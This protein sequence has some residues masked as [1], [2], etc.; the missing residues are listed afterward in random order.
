M[1]KNTST[2]SFD[3]FIRDL[4]IGFGMSSD[5]VEIMWKTQG[6]S[7]QA[8]ASKSF[9]NK[10]LVHVGNKIHQSQLHPGPHLEDL[11][12]Q[13]LTQIEKRLLW[14]SIKHMDIALPT[15]GTSV[16][17]LPLYKWCADVLVNAAT[18]AFFGESLLRD[19][20]ELLQ[21]FYA[22]DDDSWMLTYQYPRFLARN[23]H[24]AKTNITNAFTRYYQLPLEERSRA[25]YHVRMQEARQR[26]AALGE[27][28][29]AI[30]TQMFYWV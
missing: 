24:S 16:V 29:M 3:S 19:N 18:R 14:E 21:D 26:E 28:D 22:F 30:I 8:E 23:L 20:P 2:L 11:T 9:S 13:F 27:R 4:H 5:G 1:Y 15:E 25:C 10:C 6:D 12:Q 7:I 17:A